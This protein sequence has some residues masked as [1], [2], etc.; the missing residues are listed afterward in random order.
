M[1]DYQNAEH[2][3]GRRKINWRERLICPNCGCNS[4]Q[5]FVFHKILENYVQGDQI[6]LYEQNTEIY[7]SAVRDIKT[8]TGFEYTGVG[9]KESEIAGISCEDICELSFGDQAFSMVVAN[10]VFELTPEYQKAFSEAYRVLQPGG[11][12]IFTVPFD[13]NSLETVVRAEMGDN[14]LV[15]TQ[16]NGIMKVPFQESVQ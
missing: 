12:L 3:N 15:A 9:N 5:R 14:G 4:R 10:D 16:K 13:G 7:R 11:K 6:L 8:V 1:V 2:E